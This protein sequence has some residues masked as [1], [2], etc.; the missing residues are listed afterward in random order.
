M[1]PINQTQPSQPS[2]QKDLHPG[3]PSSPSDGSSIV[4]SIAKENFNPAIIEPANRATVFISPSC[5][6]EDAR[7]ECKYAWT[8]TQ[9]IM[10]GN[11][12]GLNNGFNRSTL[13]KLVEK[14]C[15]GIRAK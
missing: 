9:N 12:S 4:A 5:D 10:Q 15:F 1:N 8:V 3:S 2:S 11:L 6:S 13:N 7:P 14:Y